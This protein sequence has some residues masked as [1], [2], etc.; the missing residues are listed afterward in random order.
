MTQSWL[1]GVVIEELSLSTRTRKI[2]NGWAMYTLF[3]PSFVGDGHVEDGV[4]RPRHVEDGG[5]VSGELRF[6]V[7]FCVTS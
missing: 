7:S 5:E 4:P 1:S 2:Q 3:P 6:V